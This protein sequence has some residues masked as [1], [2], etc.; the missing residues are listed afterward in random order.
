MQL[1]VFINKPLSTIFLL[2]WQRILYIWNERGGWLKTIFFSH[3]HTFFGNHLENAEFLRWMP[4][5]KSENCNR[6]VKIKAKYLFFSLTVLKTCHHFQSTQNH[7]SLPLLP[8]PLR[9]FPHTFS[10][11]TLQLPNPLPPPHTHFSV[12][13]YA[14]IITEYPHKNHWFAWLTNNIILHENLSSTPSHGTHE[15]TYR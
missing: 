4:K 15:I 12:H 11:C 1:F 7:N 2:S 5:Q 13:S 10:I 6:R 9:Q 3:A 8:G 14:S